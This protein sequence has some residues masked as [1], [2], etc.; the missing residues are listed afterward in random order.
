MGFYGGMPGNL[1]SRITQFMAS[2]DSLVQWDFNCDLLLAG[3]KIESFNLEVDY[4]RL[5]FVPPASPG[6]EPNPDELVN[7]KPAG[8]EYEL[9]L[10]D[11]HE[12][13]YRSLSSILDESGNII[14][15]G[16]Y[17]DKN[18]GILSA[19][20]QSPKNRD[21]QLSMEAFAIRLMINFGTEAGGKFLGSFVDAVA[22]DRNSAGASNNEQAPVEPGL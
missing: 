14:N 10:L 19:R 7:G 1:G 21:M 18:Q 6:G 2:R 12:R 20:I 16:R 3:G 8:V 11:I 17:L 9:Q 15:P 5:G 13:A 4:A 22:Q